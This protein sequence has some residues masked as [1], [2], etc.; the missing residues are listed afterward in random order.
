MKIKVWSNV[1]C[2]FAAHHL[3]SQLN[4]LGHAAEI[5]QYLDPMDDTLHILYQ[6]S[7]KVVLPPNYILQ[8][9]EAWSSHWFNSDYMFVIKRALAV[10]DYSVDNQHRY[11]HKNKCIVSPGINKQEPQEKDIDNLFYGWTNGSKRR[12]E[13]LAELNK[14][15][16]S[17]RI[18]TNT[19]G[20][21]IWNILARTK[22]VINIH[23]HDDSPLEL[24]RLHEALSFGCEVYL[25]DE[26]Y[27]YTDIYDNLREIKHGLKIAGIC[28]A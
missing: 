20:P 19:C 25:Y 17:L 6:V 22:K 18:E 3:V 11:K 4:I 21:E 2:A 14:S 13:K 10:W 1:H 26:G 7:G 28:L 9:T 15:L 24:Y 23:Y 16:S 8:Q 27:Y 12:E 5:V